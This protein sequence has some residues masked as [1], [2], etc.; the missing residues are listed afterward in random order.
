MIVWRCLILG[1]PYGFLLDL[2]SG[3]T[4]LLVPMAIPWQDAS[5]LTGTDRLLM[6]NVLIIACFFLWCCGDADTDSAAMELADAAM[7][8]VDAGSQEVVCNMETRRAE[9]EGALSCG[10]EPEYVRVIDNG[11]PFHIF[12]YEA[13]HPLATGT[14]AFPCAATLGESF[15]APDVD[16]EACSVP[17]VVPWHSVKW[18]DADAACEAIGWRLCEEEELIRSCAGPDGHRYTFGPTFEPGTCNVQDAYRPE[19]S[20]FSSVAPTGHFEE[21]VSAE[22]AFDLTGNLWEWSNKRL[23]SDRDARFYHSAGWRTVAERHRDTD[24]VC[25]VETFLRGFSARSYFGEFVGFRCC[26]DDE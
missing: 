25:T 9:L 23:D 17:G 24:Q 10:A 16:T 3:I 19:G 4:V 15:Q 13:S 18:K 20:D 6:R 22:G 8:P 1:V 5:N 11:R 7:V 26:R 14:D 2:P 12:K 21:C